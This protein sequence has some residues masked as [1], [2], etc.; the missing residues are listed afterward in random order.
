M[1]SCWSPFTS[2]RLPDGINPFTNNG[3]STFFQHPQ[4]IGLARRVQEALVAEFGLRDLGVAR[5]DLAMVRPT[6]YPAVLAE[7]L[8]LMIPAQEAAMR[9]T[10]GRQRYA[11]AIVAGVRRFFA[12]ATLSTGPRPDRL[13]SDPHLPT[14]R[15]P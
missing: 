8:F 13:P 3:T 2:T 1:R 11:D 9:T 5:G 12:D 7:G 10:E 6:W 15:V 4:A 14:P